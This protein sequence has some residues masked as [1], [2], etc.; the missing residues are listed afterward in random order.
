[1][2]YHYKCLSCHSTIR[3]NLLKRPANDR[4]HFPYRRTTHTGL[5]KGFTRTGR[6]RKVQPP[7]SAFKSANPTAFHEQAAGPD[8]WNSGQQQ[9]RTAWSFCLLPVVGILPVLTKI[10]FIQQIWLYGVV[11]SQHNIPEG[12]LRH[13]LHHHGIVHSIVGRSSP[14]K[15]AMTLHQD[16]RHRIGIPL[17]ECFGDHLTGVQLIG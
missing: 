13:L 17:R 3:P 7:D 10:V 11:M 4:L 2:F 12:H 16:R 8:D 5:P 14:G 6:N 1:M 9:P 15:R